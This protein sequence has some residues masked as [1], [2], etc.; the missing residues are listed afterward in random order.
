MYFIIPYLSYV[1][2]TWGGVASWLVHSSPD[3]VDIDWLCIDQGHC[4]AFLDKTVYSDSVS[5]HPGVQMGTGKF[6]A[7]GNPAMD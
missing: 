5:P 4:V 3:R 1:P 6:V 2:F 7:E